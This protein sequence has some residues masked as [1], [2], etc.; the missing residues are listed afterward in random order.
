MPTLEILYLIKTF[1]LEKYFKSNKDNKSEKNISGD[2]ARNLKF[3]TGLR[4]NKNSVLSYQPFFRLV[5]CLWSQI[6][7]LVPFYLTNQVTI[8]IACDADRLRRRKKV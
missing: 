8:M 1:I 6:E 4:R 5:E 3:L 2:E 7:I